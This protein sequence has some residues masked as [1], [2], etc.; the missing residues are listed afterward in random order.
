MPSL[1]A[2]ATRARSSSQSRSGGRRREAEGLH[3]VRRLQL[4]EALAKG[5]RLAQSRR[6]A[7]TLAK[8]RVPCSSSRAVP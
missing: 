6:R 2:K 4:R 8:V 5:S 3:R 1:E 7:S